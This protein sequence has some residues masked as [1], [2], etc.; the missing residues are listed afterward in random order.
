MTVAN[1]WVSENMDA[2]GG[3]KTTE[4]VAELEERLT[5]LQLQSRP[6]PSLMQLRPGSSVPPE[7]EARMDMIIHGD[8]GYANHA[9]A[10]PPQRRCWYGC[11]S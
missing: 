2:F 6:P 9:D 4:E 8:A 3:P 5:H 1:R 10:A 11:R 7:S